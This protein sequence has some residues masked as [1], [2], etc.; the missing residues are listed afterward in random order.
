MKLLHHIMIKDTSRQDYI[1]RHNEE[2]TKHNGVTTTH[3]EET[4]P[5]ND[6]QPNKKF[7]A[8]P[9]FPLRPHSRL[10]SS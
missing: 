5:N 4:T 6:K 2:T 7:M 1:T 10:I 8:F 9:I 3:D